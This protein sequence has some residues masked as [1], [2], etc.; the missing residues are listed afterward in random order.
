[1][2]RGRKGEH[3]RRSLW[4]TAAEVRGAEGC[5]LAWKA[6]VG[7]VLSWPGREGAAAEK[8]GAEERGALLL[9]ASGCPRGTGRP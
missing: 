9:G 6:P 2:P 8:G 1:M 7:A 3:L 5:L 4:N